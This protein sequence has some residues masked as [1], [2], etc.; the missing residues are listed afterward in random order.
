MII[1][2][3]MDW[4]LRINLRNGFTKMSKI[5]KIHDVFELSYIKFEP[6]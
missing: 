3:I 1:D 4:V 5:D 2:S 6:A